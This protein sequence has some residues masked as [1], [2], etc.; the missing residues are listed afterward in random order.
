MSEQSEAKRASFEEDEK[1]TSH[2]ETN[3]ILNSL[4]RSPPPCF[5]KNAPRLARRSVFWPLE[6]K[7]FRGVVDKIDGAGRATISYEDGDT[8]T[9]NLKMEKWKKEIWSTPTTQK[10]RSLLIALPVR[11]TK[12]KVFW[13]LEDKWF[14]G[15]VTS[16]DKD[17]GRTVIR[18]DD[19]EVE[20]IEDIQLERWEAVSSS[21]SRPRHNPLNF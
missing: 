15:V 3:V 18:Y 7:W 21:L 20:V 19:G 1:Y 12:I 2:Y 5:I 9:L 6:Q 16:V 11:G 10:P 4:A 8:E 17:C 14:A 13:P